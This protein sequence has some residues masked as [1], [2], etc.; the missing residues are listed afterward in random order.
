MSTKAKW[1]SQI[2]T[3]YDSALL[4][5]HVA[6]LAPLLFYDDFIGADTVIPAGGSEESGC[7]W[8]KK[9]VGVAPPTVAVKAD[10]INGVVECALTVDSQKQD[11]GLYMGDQ[12]QFSVAQGC[13]F[14]TRVKISVLPTL[15]AEAVWGLIG[16]WADGPDA[17]T[18]SA[19]FTADGSGE[20][21]CEA[22]DNA[23]DSSVTSGVTA[24]AAQ[25]KV[26]RIDFRD[27]TDVKFFIDGSR[28][29]SGTTIPY[30]AT[31]ANATLQPYFGLYKASGAGL[32][33][34]EVDFVRIWQ[35]RS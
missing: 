17:I 27:V 30:A 11:A 10:T 9:I 21:F 1:E 3:F 5:E 19:F 34:I 12:R 28:V 25:W 23:T 8:S 15:L 7:K 33:K 13:V 4:Y 26:Y 6:P 29:G 16:D 32:G 14:E 18:Y 20:V 24:T 22:D 31:G 2:L 35:K